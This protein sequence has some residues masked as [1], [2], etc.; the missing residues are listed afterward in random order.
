MYWLEELKGMALHYKF[1]SV[2]HLINARS[3]NL[4][5]APKFINQTFRIY[6]NNSMRAFMDMGYKHKH[7][8]PTWESIA[9][10]LIWFNPDII[11]PTTTQPLIQLGRSPLSHDPSQETEVHIPIT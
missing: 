5:T 9:N 6:T 1:P 7:P 2:D 10:Q 8:N 4:T 11:N 3:F